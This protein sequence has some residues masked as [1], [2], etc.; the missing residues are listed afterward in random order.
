M[1]PTLPHLDA[2]VIPMRRRIVVLIATFAFAPFAHAAPGEPKLV[3]GVLEWPAKL[4]VEPFVIVRAD[5]GKLYYAEIK[6]AKRLEAAPLTAGTRVSLLGSE[7]TKP[8]EMTAI[9]LGSG[10]AATLAIALMPHVNPTAASSVPPPPAAIESPS[11]PKLATTEPTQTAM[12]NPTPEPPTPAAPS[13]A[14]GAAPAPAPMA[15]TH[16]PPA[17]DATASA[18]R[19]ATEA[20]TEKAT[21]AKVTAQSE[22][23]SQSKPTTNVLTRSGGTPRWLE[24]HGTVNTVEGQW[25][26]VRADDGKVTLVDFS[27]IRGAAASSLRPG[28]S[29]VVY[30]TLNDQKFQAIGLVQ[31]EDRPTPKSATAPRR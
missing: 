9:A 18:D 27:A 14:A 28:S 4:T 8:H 24:L 23:G 25:V 6:A 7:A 13:A 1:A 17:S 15:K 21:P 5:D 30:G 31:Q 26:A 2:E 29:I 11:S 12:T 10:D 22:P 20:R 16:Q 3:Q 19:R